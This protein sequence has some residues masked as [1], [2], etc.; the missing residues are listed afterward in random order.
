MGIPKALVNIT[1]DYTIL[2]LQLKNLRR[3]L[4]IDYKDII[5]VVGYRK[6]LIMERWPELTFVTNA[7]YKNTCTAKSLLK[8][9]ETVEN[10]D[11]LWINGDV[12]FDMNIIN[13]ILENKDQN[14]VIVNN[15][16]IGKEEIKYNT[17]SEGFVKDVSKNVKNSFGEL[18]GI[19]FVN[20]DT[21]PVFI[22][23]LEMSD[24]LD[25]FDKAIQ[26]TIKDGFKFI[27]VDIQNK[28]TIEIDYP[29][30]LETA[31][32]WVKNNIS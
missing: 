13:S 25:Y 11:V 7:Y 32:E 26:R 3:K 17:N 4:N 19:N 16:Q 8:G 20:K 12:V 2:D 6:E 30:E 31:K 29:H 28:F 14:I 9:L 22:S 21:L 23:N 24:D 10:N 27:P 1:D 15:K 18:I 5:V